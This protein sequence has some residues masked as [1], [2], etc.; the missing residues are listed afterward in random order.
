LAA[1]TDTWITPMV[2]NTPSWVKVE[3]T[4]PIMWGMVP[5]GEIPPV[6]G[7]EW[8]SS[9]WP[10]GLITPYQKHVL[11]FDASFPADDELHFYN[12][13]TSNAYIFAHVYRTE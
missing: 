9:G 6:P 7:D 12:L 8:V 3:T 10:G 4:E 13:G 5:S 11:F 1:T 2:A